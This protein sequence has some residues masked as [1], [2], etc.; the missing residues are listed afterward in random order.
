[1]FA[2]K[3]LQSLFRKNNQWVAFFAEILAIIKAIIDIDCKKFQVRG[4][5]ITLKIEFEC[6]DCIADL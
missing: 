5:E 6:Y 1:M 2:N 4:K 3:Y